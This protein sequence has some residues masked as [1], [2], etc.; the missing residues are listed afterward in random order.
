M[1]Y[2]RYQQQPTPAPSRLASYWKLMRADRP[3][4][5]LLLL[6]PTWW[7]LWLA[8]GGLPAPW[9]LF[10]F[11]AGVWL[12]RSAGCVI[13]DY[14]DRWLDPHVKRTQ[15]R[16]LATGAVSGRQ[17]LA[18]FAGLMLVAFALVLTLNALTIGLSFVGVFLAATYPYLKRYTHLPQVYL[19]MAFGWGIPMAFAAVQGEVPPLGWVLYAAN[20]LWS[21]AYDTWYAMVDRDDDLKVGSRSTAILFGDL[22]LVIQGILYALFFA[23]MALAGQRAGLGMPYWAGLGVAMALVAWEFWICRTRERQACFRAFLH[24]NWV[25]A[26]LFAGIVASQYLD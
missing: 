24:N 1:G 3:I 23:A 18:L 12:T 7:A 16:P 26:A 22:D 9:T 20:I 5:T 21:T 19:G 13:N 10:V 2:E 11:T 15:D 25:G 4:G 6:W 14:A 8:S 17:A